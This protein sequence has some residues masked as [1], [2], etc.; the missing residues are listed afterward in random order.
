MERPSISSKRMHATEHLRFLN[1]ASYGS[2]LLS[3]VKALSS[4][5]DLKDPVSGEW[6]VPLPDEMKQMIQ[7][8][9]SIPES[10]SGSCT[11]SILSEHFR[12]S[13]DA[14][15]LKQLQRYQAVRC[16]DHERQDLKEWLSRGES[17]TV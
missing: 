14:F 5:G 7:H 8:V 16:L 3:R 9:H 1:R 12:H 15:L 6:S 17:V 11:G 10:A 13:L 2:H 4:R